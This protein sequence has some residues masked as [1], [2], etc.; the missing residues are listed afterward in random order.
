MLPWG[1]GCS[2]VYDYVDLVVR[3]DTTTT[4]AL[5]TWVAERHLRGELRAVDDEVYRRNEIWRTSIDK[6]NCA[7][8]RYRPDEALVGRPRDRLGDS[9][10]CSSGTSPGP[11]RAHAGSWS[12]A[13]SCCWGSPRSSSDSSSS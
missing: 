1:V 13:C 6:R 10:T 2:I 11:G 4:F 12:A 7:V 3:N 5:R 9:G 8:V